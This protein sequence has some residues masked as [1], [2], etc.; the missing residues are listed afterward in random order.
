M[1]G[2]YLPLLLALLAALVPALALAA[3]GASPSSSGNTPAASQLGTLD[4]VAM[5]SPTDGW[6]VGDARDPV[7][8]T[9]VA[10]L[11]YANGTWTQ[12]PLPADASSP[13]SL[14]MTSPRDGWLMGIPTL[15]YD[16]KAWSSVATPS[17]G[18]TGLIRGVDMVSRSE[19]WAVSDD[20][21]LQYDN[22]LWQIQSEQRVNRLSSITMLSDQD[23][24]AVGTYIEVGDKVTKYAVILHG[25]GGTWAPVQ[26]GS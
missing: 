4:S 3:C 25:R 24:W 10:L 12:V 15:H 26:I 16:G 9:T 21:I 11:H 20:A 5:V 8:V 22:G 19:G 2:R 23:G 6:A 7:H 1:R 14:W 17:S 13:Y 18:I